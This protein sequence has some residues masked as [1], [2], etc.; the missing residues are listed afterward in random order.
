MNRTTVLPAFFLMTLLM[1]FSVANGQSQNNT[2]VSTNVEDL[3]MPQL[4][5]AD[6]MYLLNVP[7]LALPESYMDG[8]APMLTA[9]VDNS[10][11][12]HWRPVFAQLQYECGQAS[13][14]G[15]NFTYEMCRI[16]DLIGADPEN[17]FPTHFVWNF[18]NGG[19]GYWG[20]SFFHSFE[21]LRTCGTPDLIEYGGENGYGGPKRWMSGYNDYY[22]G[23]HN[24]VTGVFAID[25]QTPEGM[26]VLKHWIDNHLDDSEI[27][28]VANFY[29][30]SPGGNI[31]PLPPGTP[32]EG[33][34][35]VP[36]WGGSNHSMTILGYNDSIRY[37]FNNDGF[38]TNHI[39]ITGDGQ[40]TMRDWEIGGLKFAN[41]YSGGP[42]WAN[43]GFCYMMYKA[44]ADP[45]NEGG[46][47]SNTAYVIYVKEDCS[48]NLTMKVTLKHDRRNLIKV[49]VGAALN[50]EAEVPEFAYSYPIFHYQGGPYY[51]KGGEEEE[52]KTIEFGLDLTPLLSYV[53]SG[54]EA[55]YFFQ[56]IEQDPNG[57]GEGEIVKVSL[58]DY[59]DGIVEVPFGQMN[60]PL[61]NDDITTL[62]I[63]HTLNYDQVTIST[64]TLPDATVYEPYSVQ[65]EAENGAEPYLWE[66]DLRYDEEYS[67]AD[68]PVVDDQDISPGNPEDGYTAK[69]IDFNFPFNGE[70]HNTIYA[71][72]D[73]FIRFGT[74]VFNWPYHVYDFLTW[75]KNPFISPFS[76]DLVLYSTTGDGMF[77]E[78]NSEYA[79]F[80]WN[81]SISGQYF[82]DVQFTVI[83]F[84]SGEIEYY[85]GNMQYTGY[86]DFIIGISPGDDKNY[87]LANI[88]T[89]VEAPDNLK[90]LFSPQ[91][92]TND[93]NLSRDG[94]LSFLP[95]E[96]YENYEISFRATDANNIVA[97]KKI[98]L[99]TDGA[100]YLVIDDFEISTIDDD[101]IEYGETV[102]L[103]V[104][105][106]NLGEN[107]ITNAE[108]S[109]STEDAYLNFT[110]ANESLGDFDPGEI[111]TFTN[112]FVFDVTNDVPDNH[113]IDINTTITDG[114]DSWFSHIYI[115]AYA[116]EIG[117]SGVFVND[118]GNNALDP[119]E[120][121]DIDIIMLNGG[122]SSASNVNLN[123]SSDNEFITINV[124][125]AQ[126]A[127][128]DS[129]SY[130][131]VS[132]NVT[133]AEE[134]TPGYIIDL[135]LSITADNE[136]VADDQAF[137]TVGLNSEE[138]ETGDFSLYPWNFSGD[139]DWLI[140]DEDPYEGM[141]CA[142][143]G[144]IG[145]NEVS[146]MYL[147]ACI[148]ANGQISFYRKVSSEANYDYLKFYI[149]GIEYGAWDGEQDWEQSNYAVTSGIHTFKWAFEKDYSVSNGSD[150]GWI[151][152]ITLPPFGDAD[153]Q[154]E[155]L[156]EFF[157]ISIDEG[158]QADDHLIIGNLGTGSVVYHIEVMDTADTKNLEWLVLDNLSGGLNPLET[159]SIAVTF[160]ATDLSVGMYFCHIV[161]RDHMDNEYLVEVEL[162]VLPW[163]GLSEEIIYNTTLGDNIP[164]P[165]RYSTMIPF[166]LEKGQ[167]I[168]I[169]VFNVNGELVKVLLSN[170]RM[171]R[172]NHQV[173]WDATNQAGIRVNP[174]IYFYT[175]TTD[176]EQQS[177]KMILID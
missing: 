64:E 8:G 102:D 65:L 27:G 123:L 69:T 91:N 174:G 103:T 51:M 68:F 131:T 19:D 40:V 137:L 49:Q 84:P 168:G 96:N 25:C 121:T 112:A 52:D 159:D 78:G 87:Q 147:T 48:P 53:P 15:L 163:V 107:V 67:T 125:T 144:D 145:D 143:S 135:T 160:D 47:W 104:S 161:I 10:L 12:Q 76:A 28:G 58:M 35:L 13:G 39:D 88:G 149:D 164:N 136:Y 138:F 1:V 108:M 34:Y 2:W 31:T 150:C 111:K 128:F 71:Y 109:I 66:F 36:S 45:N 155:I 29:A 106:K 46:I 157:N 61:N 122:G 22:S 23:M 116:P 77:Y 21:V 20:V 41:T 30:N 97:S 165:F 32:E 152:N 82:S 134:A 153:P 100:N 79:A 93:F 120:T 141:Y 9:V 117:V 162:E 92:N 16:R 90:I 43:E 4:S 99:S 70:T 3:V 154:I 158:T 50:T 5:E 177:G 57:T 151:D 132:F 148:L 73:G 85:Y 175:L 81:A 124:T 7:E 55:R 94:L 172:G 129:Y 126:I 130:E 38:Y 75:T 173:E 119:G 139:A 89:P 86:Q 113:D 118:A 14:I 24:R 80:R 6:K 42:N 166:S 60:V 56:V 72:V 26:E 156:P 140:S 114:T 18:G 63:T 33:M 98:M 83:L 11:N 59:T 176:K 110:D 146:E 44:F 127:L 74:S 17:Q 62:S 101:V 170:S 105:I 54:Q 167:M 95:E 115:T 142:A 37:D 169:E 133:A 171:S